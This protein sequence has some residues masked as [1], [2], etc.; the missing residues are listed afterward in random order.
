MPNP[1]AFHGAAAYGN[2]MIVF[3]GHNKVIL[4]D[5]IIFNTTDRSWWLAQEIKGKFPSKR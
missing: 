1:R 5:Y 3:G 2:K 4:Q